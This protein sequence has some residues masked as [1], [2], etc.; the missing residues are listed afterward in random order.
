MRASVGEG[1]GPNTHGRRK[2]LFVSN[3]GS[4]AP[5]SQGFRCRIKVIKIASGQSDPDS[6][7]IV[8]TCPVAPQNMVTLVRTT[9]K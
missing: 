1:Q 7:H 8:R 2:L 6:F 9:S 5:D 4:F 3:Q